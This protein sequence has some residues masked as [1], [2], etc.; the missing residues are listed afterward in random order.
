MTFMM[1]QQTTQPPIDE[2]AVP[3]ETTE[4][5]GGDLDAWTDEAPVED[6]EEVTPLEPEQLYTIET[7]LYTAIISNRGMT[8]RRFTLKNYTNWTQDYPV[9][10]IRYEN[11][12]GELGVSFYD[13]ERNYVDTRLHSFALEFPE[14]SGKKTLSGDEVLTLRGVL[15]FENGGSIERTLEFTGNSYKINTGV[16][17]KNMREAM[18]KRSYSLMWTDGLKYQEKNTVDESNY[19]SA[20]VMIQDSKE[21]FDN[22]DYEETLSE[23]ISGSVDYAAIK[24]KYF[25]A[26]IK[27]HG[28]IDGELEITGKADRLDRIN[29]AGSKE[30]DGLM[31]TYAINWKMPV[32][33]DDVLHDYTI[34]LGPLEYERLETEGMQAV[35][36]FGIWGISWIGENMMLPVFKF[37][38][39]FIPNYGVAIII[40]S[41]LIKLVLIPLSVQQQRSVAKMRLLAPEQQ[42]IRDKFKDDQKKQQQEMMKL[43]QEY[44]INPMGG[45]F[46]MLLQM[47]ILYALWTLFQTNIDLRQTHFFGWITDL[48]TPDVLFSFGFKLPLIGISS[49]S[50][51]ALVMGVTLFI[52]QKQTITDPNQKAIVYVMPIMLTLLFSSFPSGLNLYYFMFNLIGIGQQVYI[53]SY[54]KNRPTLES[55]KNAPKKESWLQKKMAEAQA[56]AE[57]QGRSVPGQEFKPNPNQRKKK[58]NTNK[59]PNKKKK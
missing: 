50:G 45:C 58:K 41:I 43:Y 3:S 10:L 17:F 20:V 57:A 33:S 53:N 31:E 1:Y 38:H 47:P 42:R 25:V 52:Q 54:S 30:L 39:Y 24:S 27:P 22:S 4:D 5:V 2:P 6:Q 8:I 28:N 18:S 21:V 56:I 15:T 55:L 23:E 29:A 11:T 44:G 36:D 35:V 51:L 40:F 59:K 16:G 49:V 46:P 48:S 7:D 19:S 37:V 32:R 12:L 13:F 34:Y 26:A 9:Q 14:A